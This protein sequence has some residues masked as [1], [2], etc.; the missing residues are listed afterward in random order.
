MTVGKSKKHI[1]I[2]G[3]HSAF[4]KGDLAILSEMITNLEEKYDNLEFIIGSK[5]PIEL[6]VFFQKNNVKIYKDYKS[7]FGFHTFKNLKKSNLLIFGGGGL[8]FS[9]K[10]WNIGYSHILNLFIIC[11]INKYIYKKPIYILGVGASHLHTTLSLY[12]TKFILNASIKITVRDSSTKNIFKKLTQKKIEVYYDPV[13]LLKPLRNVDIYHL[14]NKIK[15]PRVLVCINNRLLNYS[16][17]LKILIGRLQQKYS[18][19]LYSNTNKQDCVLKTIK[20]ERLKNVYYMRENNFSPAELIYF[21]KQFDYVISSPMHGSIFAYV[22]NSRLITINYDDKVLELNKIIGNDNSVSLNELYKIPSVI[23]NYKCY[24]INQRN[25][26]KMV[27]GHW[28]LEN[29]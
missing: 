29:E 28:E 18:I 26:L 27:N 23:E 5:K 15:Q 10:L 24:S 3:A 17:D 11:L 8:F 19:F 1:F 14:T 22:A 9:K 20:K 21:F 7:Y 2:F 4:N 12:L 25:V 13:F 16:K 6:G